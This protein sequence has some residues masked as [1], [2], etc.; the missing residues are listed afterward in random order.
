MTNR[1]SERR[2]GLKYNDNEDW[3]P[4]NKDT[5]KQDTGEE[6]NNAV[7]WRDK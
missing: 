3:Q 1:G 7:L 6:T 2:K 4:M 5:G